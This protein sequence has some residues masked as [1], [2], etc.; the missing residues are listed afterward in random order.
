MICSLL[1]GVEEGYKLTDVMRKEDEFS[2]PLW[3]EVQVC[4]ANSS[5]RFLLAGTS[6]HLQFSISGENLL[7]HLP[8]SSCGA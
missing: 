2:C 6:S 7:E 4:S 8:V 5:G 3:W 1:W